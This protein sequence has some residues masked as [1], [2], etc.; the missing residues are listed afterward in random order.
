VEEEK[1]MQTKP[2]THVRGIRWLTLLAIMMLLLDGAVNALPTVHAEEVW[3]ATPT[4]VDID[5]DAVLE[6]LIT[7]YGVPPDLAAS[8]QPIQQYGSALFG[9]FII[10]AP[11]DVDSGPE[12]HYFIATQVG[13]QI[14]VVNEYTG[15][16]VEELENLVATGVVDQELLDAFATNKVPGLL[17]SLSMGDGSSQ[18]SLPWELN[19]NAKFTNGP[20]LDGFLPKSD[21]L[22]ALD[23]VP[24]DGKVTAARDG[25]A[26]K[27]I[28]SG[29]TESSWVKVVHDEGWETNYYHVTNIQVETTG[30]HVYRGFY[31]GDLAGNLDDA[32][33][34]GGSWDAPHLHFSLRNRGAQVSVDG[35]DI[36]GWTI[37]L[38]ENGCGTMIRISDGEYHSTCGDRMIYNDGSIGSGCNGPCPTV[39]STPWNPA[40]FTL[41]PPTETDYWQHTGTPGPTGTPTYTPTGTNT[42]Q[43]TR[44]ETQIDTR[45]PTVPTPTDTPSQTR[46]PTMTDTP[47]VTVTHW[48]PLT[49][50]DRTPLG[51]DVQPTYR[52]PTYTPLTPTSTNTPWNELTV[53][54]PTHVDTD[55]PPPYSTPSYTPVTPTITPTPKPPTF[56]PFPTATP[57]PVNTPT[58]TNTPWNPMTVIAPTHV[59]TNVPPPYST[60]SYTPKPPTNTPKPPTN[61]PKP[62][63]TNTPKPPPSATK[64]PTPTRTRYATLPPYY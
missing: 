1:A 61:T 25:W 16:F 46:W 9:L 22:N 23:F 5:M 51:T 38:D 45:W 19:T 4:M 12:A 40:T 52:T 63:S 53:I 24:L 44:T 18:L 48:N 30:R 35:A 2:D 64:R 50:T 34:C 43:P 3:T 32:L 14:T 31:L 62:P 11:M 49:P 7:F 39:T 17:K 42:P 8:I 6:E 54:A 59:D 20:H 13:S 28:C 56:T 57:H 33:Q 55:V 27:I 37:S 29:H 15:P 41:R 26:T 21:I 58:I 36:G 10:P 47:T 60:P